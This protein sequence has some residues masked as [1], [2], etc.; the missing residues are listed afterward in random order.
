M[1]MSYSM[2]SAKPLNYQL[3]YSPCLH[4]RDFYCNVRKHIW[5]C[6]YCVQCRGITN[7]PSKKD[8]HRLPVQSPGGGSWGES[9]EFCAD[10]GEL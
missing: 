10:S 8:E 4:Y 6:Q 1:E 9:K 7:R 2:D 5:S 3:Q